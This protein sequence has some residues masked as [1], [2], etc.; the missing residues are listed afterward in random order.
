[1]LGDFLVLRL[2]SICWQ[3]YSR[4]EYLKTL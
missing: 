2:A 4:D 3:S 1:M